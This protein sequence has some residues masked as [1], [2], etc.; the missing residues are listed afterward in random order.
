M[1]FEPLNCEQ[2][3]RRL[4]DVLDERGD[5]R[6]EPALAEH[7]AACGNCRRL[8]AAYDAVTVGIASVSVGSITPS[9]EIVVHNAR[10]FGSPLVRMFGGLSLTAAAVVALVFTLSDRQR[11]VVQP[12]PKYQAVAVV[13]PITTAKHASL[14][15]PIVGDFARQTRSA[16][17]GLVQ[18]TARS[19][20]EAVTLATA[21]PPP[22]DLLQ[23]VLFPP[24]GLLKQWE[25]DLAPMA[26]ETLDV[27]RN[28]FAGDDRA[29]S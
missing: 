13:A 20:D 21:L 29:R 12:A 25:H 24:D 11:P 27:L 7:L 19:V 26:D 17:A 16:C 2:F 8:A 14:R 9:G 5:P 4:N 23:P 28:V 6:A 18:G 22:D 10:Q 3:E 1:R 15:A